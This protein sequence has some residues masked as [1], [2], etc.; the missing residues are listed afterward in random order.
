MLTTIAT[1]TIRSRISKIDYAINRTLYDCGLELPDASPITKEAFDYCKTIESKP[2]Q[3]LPSIRFCI[4]HSQYSN[5]VGCTIWV[6]SDALYN[7]NEFDWKHISNLCC[8]AIRSM[9]LEEPQTFD[10]Q[11]ALCKQHKV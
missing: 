2:T 11:L 8:S 4:W 7:F 3:Y 10:I 6:G 9:L 1:S 5:N